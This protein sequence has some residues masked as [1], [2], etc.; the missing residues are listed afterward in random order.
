LKQLE[1]SGRD[2]LM[3]KADQ[4]RDLKKDE[5][6]K[7]RDTEIDGAD[8]IAV[9]SYVKAVLLAQAVNA[10]NVEVQR[11]AGRLAYLTDV[12]GD[13]KLGEY[14]G[15]TED[16]VTKSKVKYEEGM[17]LRMRPGAAVPPA[18]AMRPLPSPV[19]P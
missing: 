16:P 9:A 3:E 6:R 7:A 2:E 8:G 10:R 5:W 13:Q 15:K 19:A 14:V 17:F 4:L 18:D 12:L 11:A 1:N